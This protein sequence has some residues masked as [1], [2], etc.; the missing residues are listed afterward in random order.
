MFTLYTSKVQERSRFLAKLSPR[1]ASLRQGFVLTSQ[2]PLLA[3][4]ATLGPAWTS[5]EQSGPSHPSK[6]MQTPEKYIIYALK[7]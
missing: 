4:E 1:M 5:M 7:L 6:H 3:R 2:R